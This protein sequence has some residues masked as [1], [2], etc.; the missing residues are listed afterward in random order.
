MRIAPPGR[1]A[2]SFPRNRNGGFESLEQRCMLANGETFFVSPFGNDDNTGLSQAAA[3]TTLQHAADQVG[4]GDTVRVMPGRYQG[5]YLDTSGTDGSPITF[6]AQA[7]AVIDRVNPVTND[8]INLE[9]ASHIVIE[10]F[11]LESPDDTTRAGIRVA[12]DG[13]N[14]ANQ[15]SEG[16]ILRG[17]TATNWGRWGIFTAFTDDLLVER[18][19]L[20]GSVLEH[21]VYV[22]NSGDRPVIRDNVIF[23][24]RANGIHLNG[25]IHTGNTSLPGVDGV[26]SDAVVSGNRIFGN[27]RGG[28]SGI[29]GDGVVDI[30]IE[31][32]VL[33]DNHAS[34]ISLYRIDGGASSTGGVIVN[35]TIVNADDA[36]WVIN[37][38]QGA[39]GATVFNNILFNGNSSTVRGAIAALE[40]SDSG[41]QSDYNLIDARFSLV[42]GATAVDLTTWQD[43]T[44]NDLNSTAISRAALDQLFRDYAADDFRLD[45]NSAARD[46]GTAAVA[47]QVAPLL[48]HEDRQR[49]AGDSHDV[50]AYEWQPNGPRQSIA[51]LGMDGTWLVARSNGS[52]FVNEVWG[53]WPNTYGW[54]DVNVGDVNG[55]GLEDLVG[56]IDGRW[57]V[58]KSLGSG[59]TTEVWGAWSDQVAWHDVAIADV[60]ADG[61]DDVVGRANGRWWV[62]L[63][64]GTGFNNQLWGVWSNQRQWDDV[65][66]ADT[67][68]DGQADIVGRTR[69]RWWVARST[70]E[71]FISE[72]WG[73]WAD[74]TWSDVHVGD[75]DNDG[76]DDIVGRL[77][78]RWWVARS[79]GQVFHNERWGRWSTNIIWED[80]AVTDVDGDGK[81]DIIG[82]GNG[83][84][85]VATS[86]GS[87]FVSQVWG[88]WSATAIWEDVSPADVD[89][90]GRADIV[91]RTNGTWWVARSTNQGFANERWGAWPQFDFA[92]V[93]VGFFSGNATVLA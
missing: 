61:K 20:S 74:D 75:F 42:D 62:A 60:N 55:D 43:E 44:G 2:A 13:F 49:P 90:D 39:T 85:W 54:V 51:G 3:W 24:N 41:L 38:R 17:N 72:P 11:R 40:G 28:G 48:D 27:G 77:N 22:S 46:A 63:S 59:F 9:Q 87:Q 81:D 86:T 71:Q 93:H 83:R 89:G 64:D 82:R 80:V 8:G 73:R 16:V 4:P 58:A 92:T 15:F 37:L 32:N 45:A 25:D 47:N 31:N 57:Y 36:R 34:G 53:E 19:R 76:D 91:G 7:G 67:N 30:R 33:F 18:N 66:I 12:G 52:Q 56:R 10:G 65:A 78:G 6:L 1:A 50:G 26:I 29:N 5:F 21:G 14:S 79:D 68:G 88:Q 23:N 84:W 69:G 35:N 70:G